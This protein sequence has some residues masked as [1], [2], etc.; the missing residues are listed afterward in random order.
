MMA[1]IKGEA[2]AAWRKFRRDN[3]LGENP[4]LTL[5]RWEMVVRGPAP[6]L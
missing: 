6:A 1:A 2:N 3:R 5:F 4:A